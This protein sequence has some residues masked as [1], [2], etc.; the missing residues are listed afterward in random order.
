MA[1]TAMA[2]SRARSY[3]VNGRRHVLDQRVDMRL[4]GAKAQ[5]ADPAKEA[6]VGGAAGHH[7]PAAAGGLLHQRLRGLVFFSICRARP[8]EVKGEQRQIG[9]RVDDDAG[10]LGDA[11]RRFE[12][13]RAFFGHGG[14]KRGGAEQLDGEPYPQS[15]KSARQIG[16]MLAWIVEV[17]RM[18]HR[19][20]VVRR[21]LVGGA[22]RR[23]LAHQQRPGAV[24]QEHA[25][26]RVERQG[27]G[28]GQAAQDSAAQ[29]VTQVKERA[30][31]AVHVVPDAL[32]AAEIRDVI[33]RIHRPRVRRPRARHHGKR[34]EA[35][36]AV[37]PDGLLKRVDAEP[38]PLVGFDAAHAIR[39]HA[40]QLRGLQHRVV[41]LVGR[42]Q[43]AAP[44]LGAE[45][46][47]ARADDGIERGH[48]A[49]GS[50]QPA[51]LCR[52]VHPVAQPVERIGLELHER[53][54]RLP[55][56]GVAVRGVGDEVCQRRRVGAA[57]GNERQIAGADRGERPGNP[58]AEQAVEQRFER[59][60]V[61]GRRLDQRPAQPG[62]V[63]VATAWLLSG[64]RD[65]ID[66]PRD[67]GRRHRVHVVRR[68]LEIYCSQ[69]FT[70]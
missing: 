1:R 8:R 27:I 62:R 65:V 50:E 2:R 40:S 48:R 29:V 56:S 52:K 30:V 13:Q 33:Q 31:G 19:R 61:L 36:T 59:H 45:K 16:P 15:W 9:R 53:R 14:A 69:S 26:V 58:V 66:A 37:H 41:G 38:V 25:L 47:L 20:Q 51:R 10:Q 57:A 44:D 46:P 70:L 68:E 42:I 67:N 3:L 43:H 49:A 21:R 7:H 12:R 11:A 32:A 34:R 18:R 23:A 28:A 55:D 4:M 17:R 64:T 35:G 54:R 39:H 60:A 6:S 5:H 22:Q 24:R 63:D